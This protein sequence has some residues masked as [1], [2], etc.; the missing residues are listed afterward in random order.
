[1]QVFFLCQA[2]NEIVSTNQGWILNFLKGGGG[3]GITVHDHGKGEGGDSCTQSVE[4]F[5]VNNK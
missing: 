1:M 5:V 4:A 2:I 3:G